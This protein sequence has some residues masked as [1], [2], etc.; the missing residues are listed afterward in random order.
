M[1]TT[2]DKL[3]LQYGP[4]VARAYQRVIA[5]VKKS[6][7]E[8]KL[9]AAI[10]SRDISAMVDAIGMTEAQI[11][12]F[13]EAVRSTYVGSGMAV[14][15]AIR[16]GT[17]GFSAIQPRA[18]RWIDQTTA[19]LVQGIQTQSREMV[20]DVVARGVAEGRATAALA[21]DIVGR[22]RDRVGSRIGIT[23]QQS[24]YVDNMRTNLEGMNAAIREAVRRGEDVP[25]SIGAN[26]FSRAQR[27]KR[28]DARVRAAIKSG[29]PL[30]ES[31]IEK[32]TGRY[33]EKF[34]K[35]RAT[36]VAR[37]ETRMATASGQAEGYFQL[38]NDP[39]VEVVTVRWQHN[40]GS[41]KEFRADHVAMDGQIRVLGD[42][43]IMDD[44]TAM[45][46]PH[47]PNGGPAQNSSCRCSPFF[48][49]TVR[50]K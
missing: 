35:Y 8:S 5:T 14:G 19:R 36:D 28:Y 31:D 26:Y 4:Q 13:T 46:Y 17:F 2:Y 23:V 1:A 11:F 48:R 18:M 34:E 50:D 30:S 12:P 24:Q 21:R 10:D 43:F 27:D 22:G 38:K 33:A 45:L 9:I 49:V 7:N 16:G 20:Q 42:P 29:K 39:E 44:G 15:E 40:T 25:K 6:I 3:L 37:Q 32:I 47:D 41:Q